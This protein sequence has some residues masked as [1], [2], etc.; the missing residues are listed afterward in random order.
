MN[1][2]FVDGYLDLNSPVLSAFVHTL[3]PHR[4]GTVTA[5]L[6]EEINV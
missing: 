5:P 3:N 2:L 6:Q 4:L 1:G